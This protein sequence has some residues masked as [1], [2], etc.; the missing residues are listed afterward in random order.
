MN[1]KVIE[2][3]ASGSFPTSGS[4]SLSPEQWARQKIAE[5]T[6]KFN[7]IPIFYK[8]SLRYI[9]S[10]MSNLSYIN[11]EGGLVDIK[12]VHANPERTIGK[13]EEDNN[14][15]LPIVSINQSSSDN[16]DARRRGAPQIVNDT[17]WS[18]KKKRAVRVISEAPRA[19]DIQ[20][21]IN[22][23]AK[24][25]ANLDQIVEQIRLIF[26]PHLVVKSKYT[27]VSQAF[28]DQETDQSDVDAPDREDRILRR[29][30]SV[31]LEAYIP[32]P[33]FLITSTGEI[34]ELNMDSS[35]Y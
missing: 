34:E 22:V 15:I 2:T 10:T 5:R 24:Y 28:I 1:S 25:K 11:S 20:Y 23:W 7:K 31:K 18:E 8:E 12:C 14:I 19:V 4:S 3:F 33:Q 9:I 13:L 29:S 16:A 32:N 35:I 30:F 21:N 26:N 6:T 17:F 27:N